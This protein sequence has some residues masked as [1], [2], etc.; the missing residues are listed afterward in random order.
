[1]DLREKK[2]ERS[3]KNAFLE[4]RAKRAIEKITVKEL[5]EKAEISKGTF[6]LHYAD[7]Y[8]LSEA[9]EDDIVREITESVPWTDFL[10]RDFS[11]FTRNL[12]LAYIAKESIIKTVFSGSRAYMLPRKIEDIIISKAEKQKPDLVKTPAFR[13]ELTCR[14][15]GCFYAYFKHNKTFTNEEIISTLSRLTFLPP[16]KAEE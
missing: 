13:V 7:I 12:A 14:V 4:L 8:A 11:S 1:M 6:Y 10:I 9:I 16:K 2:T 15:Y 3:I 5:I